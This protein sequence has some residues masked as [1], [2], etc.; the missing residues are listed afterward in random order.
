MD[1]EQPHPLDDA[2]HNFHFFR[3][4]STDLYHMIAVDSERGREYMKLK[5][6]K[7]REK[8]MRENADM[9]IKRMGDG[10]RTVIWKRE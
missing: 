3:D 5:E 8:Y 2:N 4:P 9:I 10:R 7:E 1:P 6:P